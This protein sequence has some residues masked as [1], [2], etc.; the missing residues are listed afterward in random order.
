MKI[1]LLLLSIALLFSGCAATVHVTK[2]GKGMHEPTL[3]SDI[4][5][6]ITVPEKDFIELAT[7][8]TNGWKPKHTAKMHNSL[9][10]KSAPLGATAVVLKDS[11]IVDKK[12]WS[13]GVAIR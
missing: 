6:L 7:I 2:T 9:R 10:S 4:E 13:T 1:N 8:S 11:G 12:M 3:P 5:I